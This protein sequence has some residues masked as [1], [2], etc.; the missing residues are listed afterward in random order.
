MSSIEPVVDV[1]DVTLLGRYVLE[2]CFD[3]GAV[4]VIDLEPLLTGPMYQPL[5]DDYELFSQVKVDAEAGTIVWPNGA[6]MSPR[7]LYAD[8]KPKVPA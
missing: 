5:R 2:L 7:R 6:D 4:R 8:S 3:D 1:V